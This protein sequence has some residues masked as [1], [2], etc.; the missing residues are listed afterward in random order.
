MV[1]IVKARQKAKKGEQRPAGVER[2][3][4]LEKFKEHAGT[5]VLAASST[6][7]APAPDEIEVL[8]F[9]IDGEQYAIEV[10]RVMEIAT[11]RLL[12]RVPN[13]DPFIRGVMSLR[14]IVVTIVDVR[15][16]LRHTRENGEGGQIIV[17]NDP[18]GPI[19]FDVDRVLR[20][21]RVAH[22]DVDAHPVVHATEERP[23]IR[24]VFRQQN[25]L[26]ILLDLEKLLHAGQPVS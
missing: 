1:N 6:V 3:N 8:T 15:K 5:A 7:A 12:T 10:E 9:R 22:Q 2:V 13:A 19:G 18:G 26:T 14:G 25:A 11:P 23:A 21:T 4:K 24:G 17:V 20:P 16:R